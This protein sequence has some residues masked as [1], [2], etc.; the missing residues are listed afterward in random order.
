MKLSFVVGLLK[1]CPLMSSQPSL[2]HNRSIT[3]PVVNRSSVPTINNSTTFNSLNAESWKSMTSRSTVGTNGAE[4]ISGNTNRLIGMITNKDM[5]SS[6]TRW[7]RLCRVY[8]TIVVRVWTSKTANVHLTKKPKRS[9]GEFEVKSLSDTPRGGATKVS[10]SVTSIDI[11]ATSLSSTKKR[12][13]RKRWVK[14]RLI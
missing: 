3:C 4:P 11:I 13:T 1:C 7:E 9:A 5:E 2:N 14:V 12:M 8:S 10:G 6:K